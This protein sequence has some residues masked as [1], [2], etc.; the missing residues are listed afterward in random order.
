MFGSMGPPADGSC[1][2]TTAAD[3]QA[4]GSRGV[5]ASEAPSRLSLASV[6]L[7]SAVRGYNVREHFETV[8]AQAVRGELDAPAER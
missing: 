1:A 8:L 7:G 2:S 3:S 6:K 5:V 4:T